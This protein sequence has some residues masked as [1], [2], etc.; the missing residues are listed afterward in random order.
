MSEEQQRHRLEQELDAL[1]R[2]YKLWNEKLNR[3][4]EARAIENDIA[5]IF[6]QDKQIE[7]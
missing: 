5:T 2:Q 6:K 1:K 4:S 7:D 3:L